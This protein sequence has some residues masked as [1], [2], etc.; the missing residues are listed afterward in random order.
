M[1][2]RILKTVIIF[3]I[4]LLLFI[5]LCTYKTAF[6]G[7]YS[8]E[9]FTG[10]SSAYGVNNSNVIVGP[11][12]M[13]NRDSAYSYDFRN[14]VFTDLSPPGTTIS[15]AQAINE[16]GEIA[17]GGISDR[18]RAFYWVNGVATDL[19]PSESYGANAIDINEKGQSV[20]YSKNLVTRQMQGILWERDGTYKYLIPGQYTN[21]LAQA[22]NDNG[23][24]VGT[25]EASRNSGLFWEN[26]SASPKEIPAPSNWRE[27]VPLSIND[28][29]TVVGYGR[30]YY[31]WGRAFLYSNNEFIDLHDSSLWENTFGYDINEKGQVLIEAIG[32]DGSEHILL[33]ENGIFKDITPINYRIFSLSEINDLGHVVGSGGYI[34][35][36]KTYAFLATPVPEPSLMV[37]LGISVLSLAGLRRWWKE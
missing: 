35:S 28:S 3:T 24:I 14:R 11:I 21:T 23:Q 12:G 17:G 27:V 34:G 29:G 13:G 37:L 18:Y 22:I 20:G 8:V 4:L 9:E 30:G 32:Y 26:S 6:A 19:T 15:W 2:S 33:W 25:G 16:S 1:K 7:P 5:S 31:F 36:G 10:A